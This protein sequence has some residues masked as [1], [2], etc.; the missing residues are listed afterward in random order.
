METKIK[1]N[2]IFDEILVFIRIDYK[3]YIFQ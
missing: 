1:M 3:I 2:L